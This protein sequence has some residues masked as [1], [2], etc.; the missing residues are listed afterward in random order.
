[1]S[2]TGEGA[3]QRLGVGEVNPVEYNN[4]AEAA[5]FPSGTRRPSCG[6]FKGQRRFVMNPIGSGMLI[7]AVALILFLIVK[8][9]WYEAHYHGF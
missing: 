2:A 1:M 8:N 3:G 9:A 7:A 5:R 4:S 6:H